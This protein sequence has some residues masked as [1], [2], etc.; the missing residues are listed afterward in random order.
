MQ[1][2]GYEF[3]EGFVP[4]RGAR[5]DASI[6]GKHIDFLREQNKGELLAEDVLKDARNPNS[7]LHQLFEWD[8]SEAA[9][10]YRLQQARGII[11]AVVAIYREPERSAPSHKVAAFTRIPE[12]ET[13][14]YRATHQALSQKATREAILKQAWKELQSWRARYAH[15]KEFADLVEVVDEV[16]VKLKMR[17]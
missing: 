7:P 3:R 1:V 5:P 2:V 11:R 12:G 8:D 4:Q 14:H 6:V 15:L 10:A 9:E 13:S 16:G 17:Q